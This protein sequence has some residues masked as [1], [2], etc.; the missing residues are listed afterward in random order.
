PS[1]A[2]QPSS[3]AQPSHAALPSCAAL[4]LALLLL[5]LLLLLPQLLLL[6]LLLLL[7]WLALQFSPLMLRGVQ[8]TLTCGL[9]TCSSCWCNPT[10]CIRLVVRVRAC[11]CAW[12]G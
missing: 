8:L 9:T 10:V 7:L 11:V 3:A 2:A 5:L 12:N 1:R 6:L 4:L